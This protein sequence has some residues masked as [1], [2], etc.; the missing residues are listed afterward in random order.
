MALKKSLSTAF[1]INVDDAYHRVASVA[2]SRPA[3]VSFA[4]NAYAT[5]AAHEAPL[6]AKTYSFDYDLNGPNVIA[7]AYEYVKALKE[8]EGAADC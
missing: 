8:F 5:G 4:L 2:L 6:W 1:G 7:Q 3:K